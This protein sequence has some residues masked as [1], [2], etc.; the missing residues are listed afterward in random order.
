M[1]TSTSLGELCAFLHNDKWK[2]G[3]VLQFAKCTDKSSEYTQQC[4]A[5]FAE[6]STKNIGVLCTMYDSVP[7]S[8]RLFEISQSTKQK[9]HPLSSYICS[10]PADCLED[11]ENTTGTN[12][13]NQSEYI[14]QKTQVL[15]P[16]RERILTRLKNIKNVKV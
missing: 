5:Y 9:Y 3:R 12:A 1:S 16:F 6:I 2:I 15:T 8:T 14:I 10:I 13:K 7:R 4:K 11:F